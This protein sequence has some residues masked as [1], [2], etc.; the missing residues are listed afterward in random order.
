ML[1]NFVLLNLSGSLYFQT[2]NRHWSTSLYIWSDWIQH[3]KSP[4]TNINRVIQEG[5]VYQVTAGNNSQ[6]QPVNPLK[7]S[8]TTANSSLMAVFFQILW[9]KKKTQS[10]VH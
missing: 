5:Q 8:L 4:L 2:S 10:L 6:F 1:K 9:L 3:R 7:F